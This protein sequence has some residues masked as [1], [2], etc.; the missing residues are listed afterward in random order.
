MG[1][2]VNGRPKHLYSIYNKMVKQGLQFEEIYDLQA[3]RVIV[4]STSDCYLA[5]GI[6]H[7][8]WMPIPNLFYDYIAKPKTNGYQS[9]HTKV[10]GPSGEPLE[11]QIRTKAMHAV[12]EYGVAAH[13]TYKEG[14]AELA[15]TTRLSQLRKQLFDWST[16]A[17]TSSDFLRSLSTDLFSEQVFVFTPK[18]DVLDLPR[19][20]TTVDFA[21][22]VHTQLGLTVVG[23]R[24][25]GV[26]TPLSTQVEN[27]DV[28]ELITRTN[29]QPSLDWLKFVKSSHARNKIKSYFRRLSKT[30][31]A[32]RGREALEKEFR[33]L[34]LDHKQFLSEDKLQSI[35]S[36]VEGC[37]NATGLRPKRHR[38]AQTHRSGAVGR[39]NPNDPHQRRK[40][41][42]YHRRDRRRD[43]SP[44]KVLRSHSW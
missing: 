36:Q 23:A 28:V 10:V 24:I 35:A 13:W 27:G 25:N 34:G 15:E 44:G 22:R 7:E 14:K 29:G 39:S 19:G 8:I 21:F 11:V 9:L 12:A 32:A 26:M 6:V 30:D 31:D 40:A 17:K 18:G 1:V 5:L 20:S 43:A 16:D 2:E 37:E 4:E 38:Q 41:V 3:M 33:S 42:P